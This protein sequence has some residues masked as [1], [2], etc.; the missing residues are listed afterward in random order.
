MTLQQRRRLDAT[1]SALAPIHG[2]SGDPPRIDFKDEAT[3]PQKDAANAALASF[4]FSDAAQAAWEANLNPDRKTLRDAAAQA[5]ADNTTFVNIASPTNAQVV[6]QV[7][8]LTRQ[9]NQV[10][11][12]L[13][14]VD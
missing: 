6:A 13:I 14:Q 10:I 7:K 3:Q 5:V 8:A 4:D 2:T 9:M 11:K 12:R 1:L